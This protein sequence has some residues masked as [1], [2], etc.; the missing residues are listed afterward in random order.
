VVIQLQLGSLWH[1]IRER[2]AQSEVCREIPHALST[3]GD[4]FANPQSIAEVFEAQAQ[5][6]IP[7][8]QRHYVWDRETQWEAL[9]DDLLAQARVH[10]QGQAPKPHFC[11][12][13]VVD[14]KKQHAVN[15]LAKFHV[16][17]GQQRLT[18]FQVILAAIRDVCL[19]RNLERP[20]RRVIPYIVNQNSSDQETP[21][22]EQFKLRPT[23]YDAPFFTDVLTFGNREK[24]SQKYINVRTGGRTTSPPKIVGA[25]LF[26]YDQIIRSITQQEDVFGSDTY[27]PDELM[28]AIIDAFT[29]FFRSVVIMLDNSDDAQIIFETLNSRGTPL[30]ASDLMRNYIFLRAEQNKEN[31]DMLYDKYW[32]QFEER[33]WTVDQKQGRITKPRLEF[34]MTNVLADKTAAEVQLNK[35]YQE[36]L[37]PLFPVV[38]LVVVQRAGIC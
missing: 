37:V 19:A 23:R 11:G 35:I 20:L 33:F 36:W 1:D 21:E 6:L 24:L 22:L 4:V 16:I 25:Y 29:A 14:Q 34:L 8:Y 13:L 5:Y 26:F 10:L 18:T 17:D 28:D 15:E 9:W 12:A 3:E 32:L 31:V 2:C 38:R 27:E 30:L 7:V